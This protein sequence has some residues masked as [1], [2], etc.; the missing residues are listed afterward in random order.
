MTVGENFDMNIED[1]AGDVAALIH[2]AIQESKI[3][4]SLSNIAK[5]WEAISLEVKA[6]DK[7]GSEPRYLL[8]STDGILLQLEDHLLCLQAMGS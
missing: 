1:H 2:E 6:Y 8:K 3:E 4:S 5:C 7:G